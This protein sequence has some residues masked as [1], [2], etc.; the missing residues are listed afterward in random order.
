MSVQRREIGPRRSK[1]NGK[2]CLICSLVAVSCGGRTELFV[3]PPISS[4]YVSIREC[5]DP[6]FVE[7]GPAFVGVVRIDTDEDAVSGKPREG[8]SPMAVPC[9]ELP[10]L[11]PS[12]WLEVGAFYLDIDET[13][14]GCYDACVADGACQP[15]GYE[16]AT[17][18]PVSVTHSEAEDF[19]A[20]R[21]GRLP[22]YAELMRAATGG[23]LSV[24]NPEL[25]ERWIRCA[26]SSEGFFGSED[27]MALRNR[28][29]DLDVTDGFD[30]SRL[31]SHPV[32]VGPYGHADLFGGLVERTMTQYAA[33]DGSPVPDW[34]APAQ[35]VDAGT[36]GNG[37]HPA[38][39]PAAQLEAAFYNVLPDSFQFDS[40]VPWL[41]EEL[42][43]PAY[44][45]V[46]GVRC[47]YEA[48]HNQVDR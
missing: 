17:S 11:A 48:D 40:Q 8:M 14:V 10:S 33:G 37:N 5:G 2:S 32:D 42:D 1:V 18:F 6:A 26:D 41:E 28:A 25:F 9:D 22:S 3:P 34:C 13:S 16:R 45:P 27:C 21:G 39:G 12:R 36:F 24:G 47:L 46:Q 29:P 4:D 20:F 7:A 31:R 38:F 43:D 44:N 30:L 15:R 23:A 35:L 19:C